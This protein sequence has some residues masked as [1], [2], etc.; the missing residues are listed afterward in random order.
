VLCSGRSF[1]TEPKH[2]KKNL[3]SVLSALMGSE[4]PFM[5]RKWLY[6]RRLADLE[7]LRDAE[8]DQN[9]EKGHFW[10]VFVR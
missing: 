3:N 1:L 4:V 2:T 9:P 6:S 10:G 5:S 8:T 7:R